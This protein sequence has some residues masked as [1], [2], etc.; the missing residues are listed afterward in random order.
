MTVP[1]LNNVTSW[2]NSHNYDN[3]DFLNC[4]SCQGLQFLLRP[5]GSRAHRGVL[6]IGFAR[7][8]VHCSHLN[9]CYAFLQG[10]QIAGVPTRM[11]LA[12]TPAK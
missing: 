4:T 11:Y 9:I 5:L 10:S 12:N 1:I 3:A 2:A 6:S 8:V 7:F